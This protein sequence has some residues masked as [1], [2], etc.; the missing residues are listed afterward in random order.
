[1]LEQQI[2]AQDEQVRA[3]ESQIQAHTRQIAA[4][5]AQ[6][7]TARAQ[8]T[9]AAAQIAQVT[10]RMRKSQVTNPI[11]GTVL[12]TY[13]K[14]GE[15][16]QPGQPLYKIANLDSVDVRA[17]VTEPQLAQVKLGVAARVTID[18][19]GGPRRSLSGT[20][21]W[22]SSEAEFTPT[23]I[24]TR[25]ERADLVYAVK[26]RVPNEGGVLKIGMPADVQFGTP[27]AAK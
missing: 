23:P 24:Q 2:R 5:R 14:A 6:Q 8:V 27:S 15:F 1:V 7:Q 19:A 18:V 9:S 10:D 3:Q 13:T 26:I 25:E 4:T 22:I 11:A 12:T 20:I 16:V 21:S 17:Y